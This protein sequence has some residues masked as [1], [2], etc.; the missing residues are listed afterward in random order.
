MVAVS[1]FPVRFAPDDSPRGCPCRLLCIYAR[2]L[3]N[4]GRD[5]ER[6]KDFGGIEEI[7]L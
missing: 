3:F 1:V 2:L 5:W 6:M 7:G 4:Y